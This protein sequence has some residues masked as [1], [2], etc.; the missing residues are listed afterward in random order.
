M[1]DGT[2]K[3]FGEA[4]D[5]ISGQGKYIVSKTMPPPPIVSTNITGPATFKSVKCGARSVCGLLTDGKTLYCWGGY[6]PSTGTNSSN[7]VK[8]PT[9]NLLIADYI[10]N[11]GI[12]SSH[13]C[14]LYLLNNNTEVR[15]WG[16]TTFNLTSYPVNYLFPG[17]PIQYTPNPLEQA[18]DLKVGN[19]LTCVYTNLGNLICWG[20]NGT[21][22]IGTQ[23]LPSLKNFYV[24]DSSICITYP[25]DSFKCAGYNN[26][27]QLGTNLTSQIIGF[28]D[29]TYSYKVIDIQL[30]SQHTCFNIIQSINVTYMACFGKGDYYELGL[31]MISNPYLGPQPLPVVYNITL[32]Q[33]ST[34][35]QHNCFMK[36]QQL[37]CFGSNF[38]NQ[39]G[40]PSKAATVYPQDYISGTYT[41]T[42]GSSTDPANFIPPVRLSCGDNIVQ[43][44]EGEQC[45]DGN[46]IR[47]DGCSDYCMIEPI[48][49]GTKPDPQALCLDQTWIL[50]SSPATIS[51][52]SNTIII[53][54]YYQPSNGTLIITSNT[55]LNVDGCADL[56]GNLEITDTSSPV[57]TVIKAK[58]ITGS[59]QQISYPQTKCKKANQYITSTEVFVYFTNDCSN[60]QSI[61]ITSPMYISLIVIIVVVIIAFISLLIYYQKHRFGK[62]F[63]TQENQ[64]FVV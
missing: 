33:V 15:C 37:Y 58:C 6:G 34:N 48:C 55:T 38:A 13:G 29:Y 8:A 42:P 46:T 7:P 60:K 21:G 12:G 57:V 25:D 1:D 9:K 49:P 22:L 44:L 26:Y 32:G 40:Y 53:G 11:Y 36:D 39:T 41:T 54:N 2:I 28:N 56:N 3:G 47:G 64:D 63:R 51:L 17:P 30:A 35:G 23:Y 18:I 27:G 52:D 14:A 20:L 50:T 24:G 61:S 43:S 10:I 45:D 5:L 4:T 31:T 19:T 62:L 16:D 59:F